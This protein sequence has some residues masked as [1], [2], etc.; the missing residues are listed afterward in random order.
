MA[1]EASGRIG[2]VDRGVVVNHS[3]STRRVSSGRL[4]VDPG[5]V[6]LRDG[7]EALRNDAHR[8]EKFKMEK[9]KRK[10]CFGRCARKKG[11]AR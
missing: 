1:C 10:K 4:C 6:Q 9:E 8:G 11:S 5:S 2:C 3:R 7:G